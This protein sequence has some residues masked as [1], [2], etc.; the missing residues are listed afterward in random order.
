ME[1]EPKAGEIF[2]FATQTAINLGRV[3]LYEIKGC[4]A[5]MK[6]AGEAQRAE[7]IQQLNKEH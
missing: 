6:E 4:T 7:A 2:R 5:I 1:F 3:V